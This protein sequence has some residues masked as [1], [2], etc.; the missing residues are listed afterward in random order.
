MLWAA[1]SLCFFGFFRSGELTVPT[2]AGYD[3]DTHLSFEDVSVDS[4]SNPQSLQVHLKASKTDPF[5]TGVKVFV[6][7]TNC[8]LCPVAA[9]LCYMAQRGAAAGPLFQFTD[10]KPLT[11]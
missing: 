2:E 1:A 8:P 7:R 11:R 4:L 9:V 5:R 3:P 10:K 6:G